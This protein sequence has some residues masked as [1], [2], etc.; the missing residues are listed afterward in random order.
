MKGLKCTHTDEIVLFG[1]NNNIGKLH[2]YTQLPFTHRLHHIQSKKTEN[3]KLF[4]GRT[5]DHPA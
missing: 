1:N 5:P 2:V 3:T 4:L